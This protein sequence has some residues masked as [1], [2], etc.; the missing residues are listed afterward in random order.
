MMHHT[1][2]VT[3]NVELMPTNISLGQSI[4]HV[5][6]NHENEKNTENCTEFHNDCIHFSGNTSVFGL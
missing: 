1:W 6:E 4:I 2:K 3:K 5:F